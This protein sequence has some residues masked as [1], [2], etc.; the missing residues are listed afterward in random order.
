MPTQI[1]IGGLAR[2][3]P[4]CILMYCSEAYA[5][6]SLLFRF[7]S[8]LLSVDRW[9]SCPVPGT[10]LRGPESG[11]HSHLVERHPNAVHPFQGDNKLRPPPRRDEIAPAPL[12]HGFFSD[13]GYT[14]ICGEIVV[15]PPDGAQLRVSYECFHARNVHS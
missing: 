6:P 15:G 4:S 14:E 1:S 8:T 13:F 11:C 9:A 12:S 2:H 7:F 3:T 10:K 5:P